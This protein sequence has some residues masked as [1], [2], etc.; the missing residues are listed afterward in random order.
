LSQEQTDALPE[1]QQTAGPQ[2]QT[3]AM[4]Q[5]QEVVAPAGQPLTAPSRQPT[6]APPPPGPPATGGP[7]DEPPAGETMAEYHYVSQGPQPPERSI[8][9]VDDP[10]GTRHSYPGGGTPVML[11]ERQ[12]E[13]YAREGHLF[14]EDIVQ[15][16]GG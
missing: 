15:S 5:V 4:P 11:T 14:A 16:E 8:L 10:N 13:F 2:D 12:H 1:V 3:D 7:V 6:A 9:V